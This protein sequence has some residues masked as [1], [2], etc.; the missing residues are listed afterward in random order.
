MK[1]F[2]TTKSGARILGL[3]QDSLKHYAVRY[4]IGF[5]P[6]GVGTPWVFTPEDIM[7]IRNRALLLGCS[8]KYEKVEMLEDR[9][10]LGLGPLY[11]PDA[12]PRS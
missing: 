4:G 5:Q 6:G 2:Y 8:V 11:N 9:E 12:S 7:E 1:K 10:E 3:K